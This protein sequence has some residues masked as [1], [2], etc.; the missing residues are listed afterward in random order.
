M[1]QRRLPFWQFINLGRLLG[2]HLGL[3]FSPS[4]DNYEPC[5]DYHELFFNYLIN[6]QNL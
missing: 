3:P 2:I 6:F 5:F 1:Q 4:F